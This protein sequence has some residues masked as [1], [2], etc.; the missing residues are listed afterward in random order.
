[1]YGSSTSLEL[2]CQQ[3]PAVIIESSPVVKN[4]LSVSNRGDIAML[5]DNKKLWISNLKFKNKNKPG[6]YIFNIFFLYI[7]AFSLI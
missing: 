2:A 5:L 4:T 3:T 7:F 6:I 1:M